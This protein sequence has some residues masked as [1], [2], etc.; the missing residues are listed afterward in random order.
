MTITIADHAGYCYGVERAFKLVTEAADR[1]EEDLHT[2]GP[3]IHNPQAV[4]RLKEEK[5]VIPV[6]DLEEVPSGTVVIRSHG[7]PPEIIARAKEKGLQVVDCTCPF[8]KTVQRKA[9]GLV[10]EGYRL[11]IVGERSHPEVVGILGHA[12]GDAMVIE[13]AEE[14]PDLPKASDRV[15]VVVQTTQEIERLQRIISALLPKCRELRVYNTICQATE[16]RQYAARELAGR[17]DLMLVVGGRNSGN[18]RRLLS[19]CQDA[20]ARCFHIETASEIEPG[21]LEGVEHVGLT[22]GASTPDFVIQEVLARLDALSDAAGTE[23]L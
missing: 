22:A 15:G 8:V 1:G 10:K 19:V 23:C 21:W 17:V 5:G 9:N 3:I 20:N 2:L 6:T 14:V 13:D 11:F 18:T 4:D 12:G 16:Q 7:V